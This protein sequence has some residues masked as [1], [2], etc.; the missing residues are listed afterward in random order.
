MDPSL[1]PVVC[2]LGGLPVGTDVLQRFASFPAF[3]SCCS[4]LRDTSKQASNEKTSHRPKVV[5]ER[6][7]P[8]K[9]LIYEIR[10]LCC[11]LQGE[12]PAKGS[13]QLQDPSLFILT[14]A[15]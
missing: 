6:H 7:L 4:E 11:L 1:S 3:P 9:S 2:P 5:F 12:S 8:M 13:L 10:L 15:L 14:T